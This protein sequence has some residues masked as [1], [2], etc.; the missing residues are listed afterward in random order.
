M[1]Y[2][3]FILFAA[4]ISLL[5]LWTASLLFKRRIWVLDKGFLGTL[6]IFYILWWAGDALA[7]WFGFYAYSYNKLSGIWLGGI[8][9]EDHLAG[10]LIVF[11]TR[12]LFDLFER[13]N[14]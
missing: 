14:F 9:L 2:L 3:G 4:F 7:I 10:I 13:N 12:G 6:I 1:T 5:A 11:W 8:L